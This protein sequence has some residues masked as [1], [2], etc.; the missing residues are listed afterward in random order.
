VR[1]VAV[2]TATTGRPELEQTVASVA[3]Q[4]Y[5]C[6]HYV[7]FDGVEPRPLP[8]QVLTVALPVKTGA[9]GVLNHGIV[10]AS[11]Y[12]VQE[13]L[14]CWVDDDNW[15]EPEHVESLVEAI[16]ENTWAHSLRKLVN[17]D[18]TFW[19]YD[20]GESLGVWTGFVDLN[21]Y[22]MD[23]KRLAVRIAPSWYTM[24]TGG[25]MVGDRAVYASIK[26]L[27]GPCSGVYSVNYRLNS[28]VDLRGFFTQANNAMRQKFPNQLP[29]RKA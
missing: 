27:P 6:K 10:A 9:D 28:R 21:C 15:L 4:T 29:W 7:F 20:D 16:G 2:V 8:N 19:D 12:L 5:P 23:R 1:S 17:A 3:A 13:D 26:G 24:G 14:I 22:M 11:A 18:G 25:V